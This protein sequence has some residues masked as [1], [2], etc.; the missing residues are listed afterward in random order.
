MAS[1]EVVVIRAVDG[2]GNSGWGEAAPYP[3]HTRDTVDDAW[4]L[5]QAEARRVVDGGEATLLEGSASTAGLD[6]A[7]THLRAT[8][9]QTDLAS[10]LGGAIEPVPACA[11][12]DLHPVRAD[13]IGAV[14]AAVER[15]YGQ[16]KLKVDAA[17]LGHV[18]AVRAAFPDLTL[19][20]DGNGSLGG[21]APAALAG[22]DELGLA[23]VEQP[24]PADDAE[25][26]ATWHGTLVTPVC[27]DESVAG[28]ADI[29][30]VAREGLAS[31]V[32]LKPGRLGPSL[33]LRGME[34]ARRH[35]LGVKVGGLVETGV[36]KLVTVALATHRDVTLPS[37]LA[38]SD[39][40]FTT[41][42]V[43][44]PWDLEDGCLVPAPL[45][46]PNLRSI[47]QAALRHLRIT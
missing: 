14:A 4:S 9:E 31:A 44:P 17:T 40:F 19:A 12:I 25:G 37:D 30:T 32:S 11:A 28:L 2:E 18:A 6:G 20:I 36:G 47:E 1:R 38:A 29:V 26:H 5:L 33:T 22:I 24:L 7:L 3:G 43:D 45:R 41:D 46:R 21:L 8:A 13:L 42:L 10:A 39:R 15:G 34:L 23:Y 35:G 27:L 16:V